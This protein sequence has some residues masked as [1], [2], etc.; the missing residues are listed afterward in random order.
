MS[1]IKQI[2]QGGRNTQYRNRR[3]NTFRRRS[4]Q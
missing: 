1:G 4:T 2:Y 3:N